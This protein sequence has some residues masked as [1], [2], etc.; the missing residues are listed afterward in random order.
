MMANAASMR[1]VDLPPPPDAGAVVVLW[2]LVVEDDWVTEVRLVEVVLGGEVEEEVVGLVL[3]ELLEA[4]LDDDEL[5]D[6][7][8][9][10]LEEELEDELEDELEET[11]DDEVVLPPEAITFWNSEK[12]GVLC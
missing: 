10:E 2:P 9:D 11:L 6:G 3:E 5:A 4:T 7:L 12:T 8:W 1:V